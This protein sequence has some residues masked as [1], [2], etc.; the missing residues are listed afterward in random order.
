MT[1]EKGLLNCLKDSE[2]L[3]STKAAL[4]INNS[5][6]LKNIKMKKSY[7]HENDNKIIQKFYPQSTTNKENKQIDFESH[8]IDNV[9]LE[10]NTKKN[11]NNK[12]GVK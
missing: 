3:E 10:D 1:E 2:V 12:F 8:L 6:S 11:A 5:Q 7:T 4:I 9:S